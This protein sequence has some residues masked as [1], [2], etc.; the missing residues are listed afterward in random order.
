MK[1]PVLV[2][3]IL[4]ATLV[5]AGLV[6]AAG[7]FYFLPQLQAQLSSKA[8]DDD[9]K[10]SPSADAG[11]QDGSAGEE[12]AAALAE[13]FPIGEGAPLYFEFTKPLLIS[14]DSQA[15]ARYL[16]LSFTVLV[17][18]QSLVDQMSQ[19]EPELRN[20]LIVRLG[21]ERAESLRSPEGRE[22]LRAT[23]LSAFRERLSAYVD[24][25]ARARIEIEDVLLTNLVMQ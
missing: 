3:I 1:A 4:L 12:S 18:H 19:R 23:I 21:A 11:G 17:R 13:I 24:H 6:A 14:L 16:Q 22:R 10:S 5:G 25:E 20:D 2:L 8:D 15:D 7:Y 9:R